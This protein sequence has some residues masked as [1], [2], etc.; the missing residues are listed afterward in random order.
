MNDWSKQIEE[1][2]AWREAELAVLKHQIGQFAIG[3]V[4]QQTL[5]RALWALLYA[6]Y[7]GFCKFAWDLYLDA[8]E[9]TGLRR[10]DCKDA[11]VAYSLRSEFRQL[12]TTFS[13]AEIWEFCTVAFPSLL[14]EALKFGTRLDT[15]S[16]LRPE[17]YRANCQ[18][19]MLPHLMA[20]HHEA[21]LKALVGRRNEIAHGKRQVIQS[22]S[23]YQEY[24]NAAF[25]VMCELGVAIVE[26]L[27]GQLYRR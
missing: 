2:L 15:E 1:D 6:H 11:I 27:E 22:L 3:T 9:K 24:E 8:L 16:N 5:L 20:D 7:E 23:E 10:I 4:Q 21:K 17:V 25:Y 14:N 18:K 19:V 13:D 26:S 12:K